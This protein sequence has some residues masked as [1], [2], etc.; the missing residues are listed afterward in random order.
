MTVIAIIV[1]IVCAV[2]KTFELLRAM[3]ER[4]NRL[5][6]KVLCTFAPAEGQLAV[7]HAHF[8]WR[9]RE[10]FSGRL[11]RSLELRASRLSCQG[12]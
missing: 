12:P 4:G 3:L 2:R 10:P 7:N 9:T 5:R 8:L 1:G 6:G 11:D